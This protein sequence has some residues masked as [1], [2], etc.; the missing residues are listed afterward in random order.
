MIINAGMVRAVYVNILIRSRCEILENRVQ[1]DHFDGENER[2]LLTSV[3]N[4]ARSKYG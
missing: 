2:L 3:T 1:V 4:V